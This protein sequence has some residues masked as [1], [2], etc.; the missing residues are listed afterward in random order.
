MQFCMKN[1]ENEKK[2]DKR[3]FDIP[4]RGFEPQIFSNFCALDL[5]LKVTRSNQGNLLK[6]IGLYRKITCIS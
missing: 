5:N 1:F 2:K 4:E 3:K 6:E